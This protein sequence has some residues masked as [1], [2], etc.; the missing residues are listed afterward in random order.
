[1]FACVFWMPTPFFIHDSL[2]T[3]E[4]R[5]DK[6][7]QSITWMWT[8]V[9]EWPCP[10][11]GEMQRRI[12]AYVLA[13]LAHFYIWNGWRRRLGCVNEW[14]WSAGGMGDG[15]EMKM[16]GCWFYGRLVAGWIWRCV[17]FVILWEVRWWLGRPGCLVWRVSSSGEGY[18]SLNEWVQ[19]AR[20]LVLKWCGSFGW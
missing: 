4:T 6:L 14:L 18:N 10:T 16:L 9:L 12:L 19:G 8:V 5:H 2:Y 1:M 11:D 20:G 7:R 13:V 15:D 17:V 3:S